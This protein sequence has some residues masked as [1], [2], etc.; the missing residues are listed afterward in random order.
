MMIKRYSVQQLNKLSEKY[1]V[2]CW[3]CGYQLSVMTS[4]Y[5]EEPFMKRIVALIDKNPKTQGEMRKIG[6]LKITIADPHI[7]KEYN[8]EKILLVITSDA[9]D[10]IYGDVMKKCIGMD[11]IVSVYPIYYSPFS[12]RLIKIFSLLPLKRQLLFGVGSKG[13]EPHE[14]ADE[15]VRYLF[16]D[17]KGQKYKVVYLTSYKTDV[18]DGVIQISLDD[19]RKKASFISVLKYTYFF[20]TSKYILFESTSIEKVRDKQKSFYLNHGTIP[21]KYVADALRQP[22]DLDYAVCPGVGC[23]KFYTSQYNVPIE[24]QLYMMPPRVRTLFEDKADLVDKVFHTEGKQVILWLPTF[25]KLIRS[26]N[27]ERKDSEVNNPIVELF[28]SLSVLEIDHKLKENN[29]ILILKCHP[30]EK[31]AFSTTID[32]KNIFITTD[33]IIKTEGLNTHNL[34]NR[35]DA[36]VSDYSGVTFEYFLLDRITGYYI[37]DFDFYSRGFSVDNPMQY[38]PGEKMYTIADFL[39]FLDNL[40]INKDEYK[41]ERRKLVN[42]LFGDV[43]PQNGAKD[44]ID[45]LNKN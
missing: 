28:A 29:Q 25:R 45:F 44:L 8:H 1:K 41:V 20:A 3:G 21:L 19:V 42:D 7:L 33:E 30:R 12:K 2:I 37:P 16:N 11:V 5:A 4:K 36:L 39:R 32:V 22:D 15:I 14:N 24:K 35:A 9:Y 23:S 40:K 34:M 38:M 10:A 6:S 26:N 13:S 17:F 27:E 43:N 18:P 31:D